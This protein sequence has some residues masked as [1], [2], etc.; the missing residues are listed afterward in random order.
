MAISILRISLLRNAC[1]QLQKLNLEPIFP[2]DYLVADMYDFYYQRLLSDASKFKPRAGTRYLELWDPGDGSSVHCEEG[3][4]DEAQISPWLHKV[5]PETIQAPEA[6]GN[7]SVIRLRLLI[8]SPEVHENDAQILPMPF[9]TD[10]F[11]QIRSTWTLPTELLRMLLSTLP[12][13]TSFSFDNPTGNPEQVVLMLRGGRSRDWNYCL[14]LT[15]DIA[16]STTCAMVHGLEAH[17]I[18][19]LVHCLKSSREH[20]GK[21]M[22]LPL[23]LTGKQVCTLDISGSNFGISS[24]LSRRFFM[25]H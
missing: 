3:E 16:T 13:R 2:C 21:P 14:A 11:E 23:Y 10:T 25:R 20:V 4:L 18:D 22:L 1:L 8:G 12:I 24:C 7:S 5:M 9:S 19:L 17:E 6:D 15:Y